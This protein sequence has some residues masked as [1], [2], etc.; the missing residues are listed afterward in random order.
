MQKF[1]VLFSNKTECLSYKD[2][3]SSFLKDEINTKSYT[4]RIILQLQYLI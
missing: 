1:I 3:L 2:D 4:L